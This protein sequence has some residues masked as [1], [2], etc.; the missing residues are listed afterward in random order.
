M[1]STV[2]IV[3][4]MLP[5][6]VPAYFSGDNI[7]SYDIEIYIESVEFQIRAYRIDPVEDKRSAV[8]LF[9]YSL[10]RGSIAAE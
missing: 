10:V 4:I 2:L 9:K 5:G 6:L 8:Y 3:H 7:T 1:Q